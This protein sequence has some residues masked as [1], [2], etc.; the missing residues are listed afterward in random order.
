MIL[1]FN[2]LDLKLKDIHCLAPV[3]QIKSLLPLRPPA[4]EAGGKVRMGG[5]WEIGIHPHLCP[6]PSRGR[7]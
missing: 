2:G 6:P 1:L 3:S 5:G 7:K 4:G